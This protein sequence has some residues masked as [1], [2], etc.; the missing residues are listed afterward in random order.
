MKKYILLSPAKE[1]TD[2]LESQKASVSRKTL[3]IIKVLQTYT[4]EELQNLYQA[5]E[6]IASKNYIR[7]RDFHSLGSKKSIDLYQGIVFKTL[8][9]QTLTL[10]QQNYLID[11]CYILSALYGPID[12]NCPI[13]PYRLDFNM[14]ISI[15]KKS[16]RQYWKEELSELFY[17]TTL[18]NIASLEFSSL[19]DRKNTKVIDF[20]FYMDEK[21]S[22]KAPS[23]T[24][25]KLRGRLLRK[26]GELQ[27]LEDDIFSSMTI[28][29][30][31]FYRRV[32]DRFIFV[33]NTF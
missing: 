3:E 17:G 20:D 26:I 23:A 21:M 18:Y 5:S 7:I 2:S 32:E 1:M 9:F 30:Y 19:I 10:D 16:L 28:D 12:F 24:I 4:Q 8:D 22:K 11:H 15:H 13:K 27:S 31:R 14:K 25:K 29:E 33:K 6:K